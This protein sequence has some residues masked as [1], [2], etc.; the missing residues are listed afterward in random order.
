MKKGL[1]ISIRVRF[2]LIFIVI[3]A[4][5]VAGMYLANR[6]LL[7][8]YYRSRRVRDLQA[9]YEVVDKLVSVTNGNDETVV[10]KVQREYG[11]N[12]TDS[13][14]V[15]L[16]RTLT[17]RSNLNIVLIDKNDNTLVAS[18]REGDFLARRLRFYIENREDVASGNLPKIGEP[19]QRLQTDEGS[20]RK[21]RAE[22]AFE[23]LKDYGNYCIQK[24]Y[25]QR[26]GLEYL[27]CWGYFSDGETMFL[28]SMPLEQIHDSVLV[29]S[30]FIFLAGLTVMLLG[31]LVIFFATSQ[32]TRPI[33]QLASISREMSGLDFSRRY[34]GDRQDEIGV[35]G[36][37]MNLMSEKLEST[38]AELK[39]SNNRLLRDIDEKT[40]IDEMR[41]DFVA[42]VSHELKTP[43]ALIEGYAEGL[44]EGIA[45]DK[46]SRDYYCSVIMDEAGKMQRMVQ[47]LLTLS[48]MESGQDAPEMQRFDLCAVARSVTEAQ[49]LNAQ[50][51]GASISLEAPKEL[52]VWADEFKAE[53]V[54]TNY[55]SNALHHADGEKRVI[56]RLCAL[57]GGERVR[58]TVYND[59]KPIP[60]EDLPHI[61]DK[62]Y[63]VDK[64]HTR[65]YGGSGIGLS[66]VKSV[67]EAHHQAYGVRN[68][69]GGVEF[70]AE[71]DA[72]V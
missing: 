10:E 1:K 66:I 33:N 41:R 3:M 63:K 17:D 28:L 21:N 14:T 36:E 37:S 53:E 57:P 42:N 9:A 18:S 7:E 2:T 22:T 16:F 8:D 32:I 29:S 12:I 45:D 60:E 35:L 69:E 11:Q 43:I 5:M 13:P 62:F 61:W 24:N 49:R 30:R 58:L 46:E 4:V 31:S 56:M 40:R 67:M 48:A 70:F 59:G 25:D 55:L 19:E 38:I 54:V 68:T 65:A 6:F 23:T 64:A 34:T 72:A 27:E 51:T 50:E 20:P 39:T 47:S 71:F 15:A 52:F 44:V 26:S